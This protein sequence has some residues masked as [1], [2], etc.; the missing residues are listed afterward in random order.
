MNVSHYISRRLR[1]RGNG[2][3]SA[4][5]VVIAVVGVAL[6]VM[7]MEFTLAIVAGFK[8]GIRNRLTGFDAQITVG[9]PL[10]AVTG[11]EDT[12]IRPEEQLFA[13]VGRELPGSSTRMSLRQ[14]G[15]LKTD[16]N[17]L[18]VVFLGQS[19]DSDF[20]FERS[21][22]VD[23]EWPD[24]AADSTRNS[25]VISRPMAQSL[26]LSVGDKVFSTF[27]IDGDVVLRRHTVAALY[28]SNFGE[29]DN[30][31]VYAS[32]AGLQRICGTDSLSASRLDIRGI[33]EGDISAGAERLQYAL[34]NAVASG[35]LTRYYPVDNIEHT[36]AMYFGW[37]ALL[38]TNV[39]VIFILMLA[40]AGLTLVSSLFILILERV[41]T[42]G[43]LRAMGAQK[44]TVRGIFV[45]MAMRLVG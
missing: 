28:Q 5:G 11:A 6:A 31:V 3:G 44:A 27:I 21:N 4:T 24:Y 23:G 7:I 17:F 37:L 14:P 45:D 20:S 16:D 29:Y 41:P 25:I 12:Y 10:D 18:G 36:G 35:E 19:A 38:D 40:V 33:D 2:S 43:I 30:T 9:A 1:L 26:G 13:I 8:D 15:L 42:I 32:L 34:V 22:V 39:A